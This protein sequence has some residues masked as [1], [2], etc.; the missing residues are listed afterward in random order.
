MLHGEEEV[1]LPRSRTLY[2]IL[3]KSPLGLRWLRNTTLTDFT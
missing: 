1:T 2:A 3:Q